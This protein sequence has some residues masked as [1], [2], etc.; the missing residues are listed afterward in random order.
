M[1]ES[2]ADLLVGHAAMRAFPGYVPSYVA[3]RNPIDNPVADAAA[4]LQGHTD[5]A[6]ELA[7]KFLPADPLEPI[8]PQAGVTHL[9]G[10]AEGGSADGQDTHSSLRWLAQKARSLGGP[11]AAR[12]VTGVAGQFYGLDPKGNVKFMGSRGNLNDPGTAPAIVEQ[13]LSLPTVGASLLDSL[14]SRHAVDVSPGP[15]WSQ[16]ALQRLAALQERLKTETGVSEAHTLPE[17]VIDAA[18]ALT[19]PLAAGKAP[20]ALEFV[21]PVRPNTLGRFAQDS[22]VLGTL[23]KVAGSA[24]EAPGEAQPQG[25]SLEATQRAIADAATDRAVAGYSHGVPQAQAPPQGPDALE[26]WLDSLRSRVPSE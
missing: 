14:T 15:Q 24:G 13:L 2:D 16:D 26:R 17:H 4:R 23:G 8:A 20:R 25:R 21:L 12:Y 5:D 9:Q 19:S 18:A 1:N 22:A 11:N 10:F 6:T 3:G 7:E